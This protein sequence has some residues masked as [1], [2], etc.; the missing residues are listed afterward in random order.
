V[1]VLPGAKGPAYVTGTPPLWA[2]LV[3][4]LA[5]PRPSD[6][7][8]M[9][10]I[11]WG[12]AEHFCSYRGRWRVLDVIFFLYLCVVPYIRTFPN[13]AVLLVRASGVLEAPFFFVWMPAITV[14]PFLP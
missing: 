13:V 9:I 11:V 10:F 4:P 3:L 6:G 12:V 2:K 14:V 7:W 5:D 8:F 1:I